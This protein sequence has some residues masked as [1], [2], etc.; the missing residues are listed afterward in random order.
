MSGR[1]STEAM[2]V[3]MSKGG[4][5]RLKITVWAGLGGR[6]GREGSREGCK[7][8]RRSLSGS[9][10][11]VELSGVL[12]G[13]LGGVR[14]D[15]AGAGIGREVVVARVTSRARLRRELMLDWQKTGVG[16]LEDQ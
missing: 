16:R 12:G 10:L 11:G 2:E 5:A 3:S 1:A 13:V 7:I 8:S 15:E 6:E 4:E 14:E 9:E